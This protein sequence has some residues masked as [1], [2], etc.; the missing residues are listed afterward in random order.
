MNVLGDVRNREEASAA[1]QKKQAGEQREALAQRR[2]RARLE[3]LETLER[4]Q[5]LLREMARPWRVFDT[6]QE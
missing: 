5:I 1:V 2:R 4:T 6:R 3:G